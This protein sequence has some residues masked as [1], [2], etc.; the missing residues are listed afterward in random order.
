MIHNNWLYL[1][2][3][4]LRLGDWF[5]RRSLCKK[6]FTETIQDT[7]CNVLLSTRECGWNLVLLEGCF[8][9]RLR[10]DCECS[11]EEPLGTMVGPAIPDLLKLLWHFPL[12][13]SSNYSYETKVGERCIPWDSSRIFK[14]Q[15]FL[16]WMSLVLS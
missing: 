11:S 8:P 13:L 15:P 5:F 4:H 1:I 12:E 9:L 2:F 7:S 16:C 10:L 6:L 3:L 14:R